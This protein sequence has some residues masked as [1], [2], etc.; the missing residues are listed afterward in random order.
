M[1]GG[2]AGSREAAADGCNEEAG[3]DED[4]EAYAG[5]T[6]LGACVRASV[7]WNRKGLPPNMLR[8]VAGSCGRLRA[9]VLGIECD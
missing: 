3:E 9:D 1:K 2:A 5:G 4:C 8:R 6:F 7:F